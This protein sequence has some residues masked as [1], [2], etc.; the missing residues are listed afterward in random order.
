[1]LIKSNKEKVHTLSKESDIIGVLPL[2]PPVADEI[3]IDS[4]KK[5]HI[6]ELFN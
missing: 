5:Y 2:L 3:L 4:D 1:M 6:I